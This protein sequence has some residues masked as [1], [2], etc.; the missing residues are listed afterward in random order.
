LIMVLEMA[1]EDPDRVVTAEWT[2]EALKQTNLDV[3]TDYMEFRS[4]AADIQ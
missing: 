3:S 2:L 1:F 4:Y